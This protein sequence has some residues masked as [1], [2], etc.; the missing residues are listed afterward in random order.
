M[1]KMIPKSCIGAPWGEE[2][3]F[4]T[5]RD[6]NGL[7]DWVVYHNQDI[8]KHRTK[9]KGE[10][11][12]IFIGPHGVFVLE[13]KGGDY[14]EY[15]DATNEYRWGDPKNPFIKKETPLEQAD[16]NIQSIKDEFIRRFDLR[17]LNPQKINYG[18]GAVFPE[19]DMSDWNDISW[20]KKL[21]Y[22]IN[23]KNLASYIA[24]LD[25][26]FRKDYH[27]NL[28]NSDIV[29]IQRQLRQKFISVPILDPEKG[30]NELL[31]IE[32]QA[33]QNLEN[34]DFSTN[35]RMLCRG[36][37]GSGKTV[38]ARYV[39]EHFSLKPDKRVLWLSFNKM[40][41]SEMKKSLTK[42]G[43]I[44]VRTRD[45]LFATYLKKYGYDFNL[46]DK[47]ND[48]KFAECVSEVE[49]TFHKWDVIIID[50]GQDIIKDGL[51]LSLDIILKGGL[52]NGNWFIFL[53]EEQDVFHQLDKKRLEELRQYSN[54]PMLL[55]ENKRNPLRIVNEL[56]KYTSFNINGSRSFKGG[57]E[58]T[59]NGITGNKSDHFLEDFVINMHKNGKR[60]IVV[61]MNNSD[62]LISKIVDNNYMLNRSKKIQM[63]QG[64]IQ[65]FNSSLAFDDLDAV[66][67]P[68]L[69]L[70]RFKGLEA[71]N[72]VLY[73]DKDS[74]K[75][76]TQIPEFYTALTRTLESGYILLDDINEK[77]P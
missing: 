5:V 31:I 65:F 74:Y 73:W 1:A 26:Y 71:M 7:H 68:C 62:R 63:Q 77:L 8:R 53:D 22:D 12:F 58:I 15:N 67:I 50:E 32:G 37:A 45:S 25:K 28:T 20:D 69:N 17:A 27:K 35:I 9:R 4:N 19:A 64:K 70:T 42:F 33:K 24:K 11:D 72:L 55:K 48:L 41:T 29:Y 61:L 56:K 60:N 51:L 75:N 23:T 18:Y 49:D 38:I 76:K 40:F 52:K 66:G 10:A 13:L 46:N 16:G 57:L 34:L 54:S 21:V 43:N 39:A 6:F 2:R 30:K 47:D 14:H 44:E 3:F 59:E 36:G